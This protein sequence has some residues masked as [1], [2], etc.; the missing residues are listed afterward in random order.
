[1]RKRYKDCDISGEFASCPDLISGRIVSPSY[2]NAM[3]GTVAAKFF[4][5]WKF[6]LLN[7]AGLI[8]FEQLEQ[9]QKNS[10]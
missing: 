3:K 2:I 1:M 10:S 4:L 7:C 9:Q 6:W 8:R 5:E